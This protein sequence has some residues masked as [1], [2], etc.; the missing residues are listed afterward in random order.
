MKFL[1]TQGRL[2]GEGVSSGKKALPGHCPA[3]LKRG[4]SICLSYTSEKRQEGEAKSELSFFLLVH[5][6]VE[7]S[8]ETPGR[9]RGI[10]TGWFCVNL[11][12]A[13]VITEKGA[14][15]EEM[16]P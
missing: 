6:P 16:L 10:C 11:T 15:G 3:L 1:K 8:K 9:L 14:L 13:G 12:Q 4:S 2:E 7:A 5:P